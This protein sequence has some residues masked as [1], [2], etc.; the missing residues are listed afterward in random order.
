[1]VLFATTP[2]PNPVTMLQVETVRLP[3]ELRCLTAGIYTKAALEVKHGER[4]LVI[5]NCIRI[6]DV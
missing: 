1:V 5:I 3:T 4:T 6:Q 2:G